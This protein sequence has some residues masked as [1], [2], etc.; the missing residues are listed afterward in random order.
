[1]IGTSIGISPPEW[2][3]TMRTPP[4]AGI[5]SMSRTSERKYVFTTSRRNGSHLPTYS[6]SRSDRSRRVGP[7]APVLSAR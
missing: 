1:M 7:T 6:A 4:S 3:D 5:R 2:L